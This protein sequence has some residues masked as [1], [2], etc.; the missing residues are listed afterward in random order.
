MARNDGESDGSGKVV[1]WVLAGCG[2][3][4]VLTAILGILAAIAIPAYVKYLKRSKTTE[5]KQVVERIADQAS[6]H[7]AEHCSFP[8]SLP[9]SHDPRECCG[10]KKCMPSQQWQNEYGLADPHYFAYSTEIDTSKEKP[11][12]VIRART[13]FRCGES[14]HTV[15]KVVEGDPETCTPSA[16]PSYTT[17]EFE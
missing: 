11:V 17:N 5:A 4:M 1:L 15:E 13:D 8:E 14:M 2:G 16:R 10:G 12:F 9:A 7:Y 3:L 6:A